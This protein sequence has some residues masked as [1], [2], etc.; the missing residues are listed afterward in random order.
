MND[1]NWQTQLSFPILAVMQLLPLLAAVLIHF[2]K[3]ERLSIAI[4]LAVAVLEMLL[5]LLLFW[6]FDTGQPALQFAERI[7]LFGVLHYHAGVDGMSVLFM[8][9]TALLILLGGVY[10]ILRELKPFTQLLGLLLAVQSS[11]MMMFVTQNLLW[12]ELVSVAH[13]VLLSIMMWRWA[14]STE[15]N[16]MVRRYLQF[17]ASGVVLV[18]LGTLVL[19]WQ[20]ALI[21]GQ[22]SFD[23]QQLAQ[24]EIDS[25]LQ[26]WLFILLCF[27]FAIRIPVFPLHGWLVNVAEHGTVG[28][29]PVLLLGIKSGIYAIVKFVLPLLPEAIAVWQPYLIMLA[30][31]G[32]FYAALLALLQDNLRRLLV[33]AVISHSSLLLFGLFSLNE[34]ALTG[35]VMLS[36]NLGL[37]LA[38][39][40][41]VTG[42]V[43]TRTQTTRL[44]ELGGLY[45]QIP[46]LAI[47]FFIGG[48]SIIGM[49]GTPGFDAAHLVFEG[50]VEQN[51]ALLT[52]AAAL[53]NVFAAGFLLWAL[54]RAFMQP[55]AEGQSVPVVARV[56]VAEAALMI[57]ITMV[58][59]FIGFYS[60][61][62]IKLLEQALHPIS[63]IYSA[64]AA[65]GGATP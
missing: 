39:L 16:N 28:T 59:L 57:G 17:M 64:S 21:D 10:G 8:L 40:L 50:G 4:G 54:Q 51:G 52:I 44:S 3:K 11:L 2:L 33:Y 62:W 24:I 19:G 35:T 15:R 53:G 37:A 41:Y 30:V 46:L 6:Q 14:T 22:W 1:I 7:V 18:L 9:M 60:E 12:F 56:S 42:L 45:E 25:S 61:P 55:P 5:A 58:M 63:A 38:S 32:V 47:V 43:Y 29:A 27:G 20:H 31:V 26:G 65:V 36:A 48:L 23:L 13:F 49:P 34:Q